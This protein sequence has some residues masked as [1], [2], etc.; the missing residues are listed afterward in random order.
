MPLPFHFASFVIQSLPPMGSNLYFYFRRLSSAS[1]LKARSAAPTQIRG[2]RFRQY[3]SVPLHANAVPQCHKVCFVVENTE[4]AAH[5]S[6][7]L[8]QTT[9]AGLLTWAIKNN[10]INGF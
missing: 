10:K 1:S 2:R 6:F 7:I 8:C 5:S 9:P 3:A 4:K